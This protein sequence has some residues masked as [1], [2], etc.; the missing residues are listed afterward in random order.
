MFSVRQHM[1]KTTQRPHNTG[2]WGGRM[3]LCLPIGATPFTGSLSRYLATISPCS[4]WTQPYKPYSPYNPYLQAYGMPIKDLNLPHWVGLVTLEPWQIAIS[5]C[6]AARL[7]GCMQGP[8]AASFGQ[9]LPDLPCILL[10][11]ERYQRP[12]TSPFH[13]FCLHTNPGLPAAALSLAFE[14][15]RRPVAAARQVLA[16][17]PSRYRPV[18][19]RS[20]RR[21][22]LHASPA[23]GF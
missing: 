9:H 8:C 22:L 20:L 12:Q 14:E 1:A 10:A 13:H 6:Q 16:H 5:G 7:P 4:P 15:S 11:G 3:V 2:S 17:R 18:Y 19:I 21:T 23:S